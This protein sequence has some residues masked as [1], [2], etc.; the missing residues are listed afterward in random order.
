[1]TGIIVTGGDFPDFCF[2]REYLDKADF[3]IAADSGLDTLSLY[4][5]EPDLVI[6]DMDSIKN[7]A[8]L[9]GIPSEKL[10]KFPQDKDFTDTELAL[11]YLHNSGFREI[12]LLGGGGGRLDHIIA[13]YTLFNR[14]VCPSMW[15]TAEEKIFLVKEKFSTRIKKNSIVSFFPVGK[16]ICKMTSNGLKWKLNGLNWD[17]G[18]SGISNVA[19]SETVDINMISGRLLMIIPINKSVF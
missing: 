9:D 17:R 18:D 15:I 8:L 6:G 10:M 19:L 3:I 2:V 16:K 12:W 4:G 1:M 14:D 11:D 13:L 5:Y 7:R